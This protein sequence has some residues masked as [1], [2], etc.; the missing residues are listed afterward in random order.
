[1]DF[2]A[3]VVVPYPLPHVFEAYRERIVECVPL[4]PNIRAIVV[5][6]RE[7]SGEADAKVVRFV[8]EW[9]GGGDIPAVVRRLVSDDMLTWTD[10]ATWSLQANT[11]D[12]AIEVHAL[13]GA[14]T[15]QGHNTFVAEGSGTR[16][17]LAGALSV[18][19]SKVPGVPRFLASSLNGTAEKFIVGS[20]RENL[21][22]VARA[23][24]ALLSRGSP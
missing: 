5:K 8:N 6:S 1:M 23:V 10:H 17:R 3:E 4:L 22:A 24:E 7:E 13:P 19:A 11:V 16:V 21:L 14:V 18:D 20:I 2:S 12:Y 15:C 9:A